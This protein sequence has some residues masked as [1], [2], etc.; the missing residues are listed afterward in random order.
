MKE[1][2]TEVEHLRPGQSLD[3]FIQSHSI[4]HFSAKETRNLKRLRVTAPEPPRYMWKNIIPTLWLAEELRERMNTDH[5]GPEDYGLAVGN[6]FRPRDL[7]KR[8][9]GARYSKH[10]TF[11]ALD[12]DLPRAIARDPLAQDALYSIACELFLEFGEKL[13]MGLG[14]YRRDRGS[15][16]HLDTGRVRRAYWSK[17]FVKPILA[18]LR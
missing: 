6:G 2:F 11:R 7:N 16:V 3:D 14:L 10:I 13:G 9:G 4:T 12:L 17:R 15:R 5:G 8:V 1:R 18:G